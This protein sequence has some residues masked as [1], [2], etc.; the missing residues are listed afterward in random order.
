M[1]ILIRNIKQE[2][3]EVQDSMHSQMTLCN[4]QDYYTVFLPMSYQIY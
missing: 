3:E 2:E 1:D 4:K